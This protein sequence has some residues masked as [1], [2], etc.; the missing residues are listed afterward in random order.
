M[1][2][3]AALHPKHMD[4]ASMQDSCSSLSQWEQN[5]QCNCQPFTESSATYLRCS[6]SQRKS[7]QCTSLKETRKKR[8]EKIDKEQR[9]RAASCESGPGGRNEPFPAGSVFDTSTPPRSNAGDGDG[10]EFNSPGEGGGDRGRQFRKERGVDEC[11]NVQRRSRSPRKRQQQQPPHGNV[12][13][14]KEMEEEEENQQKEKTAR[15][16]TR[17]P[18]RLGITVTGSE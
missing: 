10:D 9:S 5:R 11:R 2:G 7:P 6:T 12:L 17:E 16:T 15:E 1:K 14:W 3:E 18:P 4:V 13:P 8:E